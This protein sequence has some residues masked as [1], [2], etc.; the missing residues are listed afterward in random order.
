MG[1]TLMAR[2]LGHAWGTRHEG[3]VGLGH[4]LPH[5]SAKCAYEWGTREVS[6]E[7]WVPRSSWFY[8]DE[9]GI[10]SSRRFQVHSDSISTWPDSPV[11]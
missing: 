5:S 3:L 6:C 10:D 8:R 7:Y 11:R 2:V 4:P 9:W 1:C